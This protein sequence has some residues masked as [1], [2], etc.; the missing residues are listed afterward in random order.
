MQIEGVLFLLFF[1]FVACAI[2]LT[3]PPRTDYIT[4]LGG[5]NIESVAGIAVDASG[6]EY[7]AGTTSSPDFPLTSTALG[8][9]SATTGCSFITKFNPAGTGILLSVCVANAQAHAFGVDAAVTYI[10]RR[11]RSASGSHRMPC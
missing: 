5:S 1:G 9:P 11:R 6:S 2:A 8:T 3:N 7:V 4:Y 10:W